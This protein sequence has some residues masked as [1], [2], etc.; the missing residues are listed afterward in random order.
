[1]RGYPVPLQGSGTRGHFEGYVDDFASG[2]KKK[3]RLDHDVSSEQR[4]KQG[5]KWCVM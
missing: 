2:V 5:E 3:T 1:V 4:E